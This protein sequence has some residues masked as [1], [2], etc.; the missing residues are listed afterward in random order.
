MQQP[1]SCFEISPKSSSSGVLTLPLD[2]NVSVRLYSDS[3]PCCLETGSLQK[4]LVL[5]LD[6]REIIEEGV[7]FGVPVVKYR[8][9]TYFSS[10]AQL[11]VSNVGGCLVWTKSYVIDTVSRKRVGGFSYVND[12]FY[13]LLHRFFEKVYLAGGLSSFLNKLMELRG[14][15]NVHTVFIRVKPKGR[16]VVEYSFG[17]GEI[18][19]KADLSEFEKVDCEKVLLLNEQGASFFR[20]YLDSEGVLLHAS[21]I[22][23]WKRV[24]AASASLSTP[25]RSIGFWLRKL[26]L[27]ELF[28]G[29]EKTRGRFAWSG[30][31]YSMTAKAAAFSYSIKYSSSGQFS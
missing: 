12:R 24:D 5:I 11:S 7:G 14:V 13:Q 4:G 20:E 9:K 8:D 6:G 2:E 17:P 18:K 3:S 22:G 28:R 19:V 10:T 29:W 21:R 30:L 15:L 1:D 27:S 23:A 31:S 16:V 26:P 25:K